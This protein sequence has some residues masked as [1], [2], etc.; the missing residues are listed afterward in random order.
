MISE[1]CYTTK[2]KSCDATSKNSIYELLYNHAHVN[3]NRVRPP[4]NENSNNS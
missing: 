4:K 2:E 1:K 3:V